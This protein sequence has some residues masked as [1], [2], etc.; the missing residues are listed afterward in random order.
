VDHSWNAAQKCEN[1]VDP[2]VSTDPYL[3][4]GSYGRKENRENDLDHKHVQIPFDDGE[5]SGNPTTSLGVCQLLAIETDKLGGIPVV[6]C[7]WQNVCL[8]IHFGENTGRITHL[9]LQ[10]SGNP[11]SIHTVNRR[12]V[13]M[14]KCSST[15][16]PL[17][18]ARTGAPG[19]D[20][21]DLMAVVAR[22]QSPL[23]RFVGQMLG[24]GDHEAEDV[25]QET[26]IRLHRQVAAHGTGSVKNL[27]T[28]L[29]RVARNSTIDLLRRR[30]R[31]NHVPETSVA[32]RASAET[33]AA[34]EFGALGE[35]LRQEARQVALR[36]LAELD[37]E[38]RQVVLLKIIQGMSLRQVAEVVGGSVSLVNYRLNQG[39]TELARRL[40]KAGV[41]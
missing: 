1:Y 30:A 13:Q 8:P 34:D 41:V 24:S 21:G 36:E 18:A 15:A 20:A 2:E 19:P 27:T 10:I 4:G 26:F 38:Q 39:L 31:R 5:F 28:W 40:R 22:Y 37:D 9:G 6:A 11:S 25:V 23:L 33:S 29:F 3:Q 17:A 7:E 12:T 14:S 32:P 16:S 35:V